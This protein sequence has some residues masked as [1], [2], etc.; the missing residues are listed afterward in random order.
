MKMGTQYYN[1]IPY[2]KIIVIIAIV[3]VVIIRR[4]LYLLFCLIFIYG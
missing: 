2:H 3:I 4:L 1:V